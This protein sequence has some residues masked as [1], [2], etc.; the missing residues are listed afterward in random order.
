MPAAKVPGVEGSGL[1]RSTAG[2]IDTGEHLDQ[3]VRHVP[4]YEIAHPFGFSSADIA[5]LE[6][7][8]E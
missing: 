8:M 6:Q 3:L 5:T 7:E 1:G 2:M 4:V